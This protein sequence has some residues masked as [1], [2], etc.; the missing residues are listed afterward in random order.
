M[1]DVF[2]WIR[3]LICRGSPTRSSWVKMGKFSQSSKIVVY[4][5]YIYLICFL[6]RVGNLVVAGDQGVAKVRQ[7]YNI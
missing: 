1:I 6:Y 2:F 4:H 3:Q 5:F 7:D